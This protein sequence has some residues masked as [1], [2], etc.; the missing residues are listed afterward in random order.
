MGFTTLL[1]VGG[2][3]T[4]HEVVNGIGTGNLPKISLAVVAA[5][6]GMDFARNLNL[7]R[8][9][10]AISKLIVEST[11]R[12]IDVGVAGG[13]GRL[14]VNFGEVG[15]GASV[16]AR[17][18]RFNDAWPG[19]TSFFL[20]ALGASFAESKASASVTVDGKEIYRGP[21]V[22]A[23]VANGSYFG[24]G[25]K[26]APGASPSDGELN[27]LVLGDF[28][29]AELVANIWK[30]YPGLHVKH[31][32][33]LTVKGR[34]ASIEADTP[35]LLDLDGE[36]YRDCPFDFSVLPSALRVVAL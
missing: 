21:L 34:R 17:E 8:S 2:D 32:K 4:V 15:L 29:R 23:V 11:E 6:T 14:F 33:V 22:S 28:S 20:A 9:A 30:I 25:M 13:N 1:A 18:A 26:I 31:P 19:R 5:G 35:A 10:E 12:L 3:G 36:L 24:G 27:V 16:V 7:P